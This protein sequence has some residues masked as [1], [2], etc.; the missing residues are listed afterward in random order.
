[1]TKVTIKRTGKHYRYIKSGR[2]APTPT[3]TPALGFIFLII[4][5]LAFSALNLN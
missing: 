1:M 4:A 5:T 2:F 3:L